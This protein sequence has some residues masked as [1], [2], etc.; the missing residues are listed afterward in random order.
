MPPKTEQRDAD[1]HVLRD[2]PR[3]DIPF[4]GN[5]RHALGVDLPIAAINLPHRTDRWDAVAGR[6]RS[7]GLDRLI[8]MPAVYGAELPRE[9]IAALVH[10]DRLAIDANPDTH[11]KVTRPAIGCFLSHLAIWRW[12]LETGL[13]RVL[14]FEDD[15]NP[16][17]G[18]DA[19]SFRTAMAELEQRDEMVFLGRIIMN[20][21]AEDAAKVA[22][23]LPRMFYFNG[24]FAYL[25]TPS[26]ARVLIRSLLPIRGHIDVEISRILI[27]RRNEMAARYT[28]PHFFEPDWTLRS[29]CYV[30]LDGE[31]EANRELGAHL[32]ACRRLLESEHRPLLP[33]F[34]PAQ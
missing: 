26:V 19:A 8:K 20:G 13:P 34:V 9:T 16:A 7:V 12:M 18:F 1:L 10:P 5:T 32:D 23:A 33:A 29:D 21:M 11:F 22:P 30:P 25:I 15:A 14:V 28:E 31:T 27:E 2:V 24:T 3:L 4:D 6:M 17:P